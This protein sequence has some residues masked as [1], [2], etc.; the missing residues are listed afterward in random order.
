M[1]LGGLETIRDVIAFPKTQNATSLMTEAPS[2][3]EEEQLE[4]L[5]LEVIE[6]EEIDID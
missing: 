1:L 2:R 4:E 5:H 6:E 3:V